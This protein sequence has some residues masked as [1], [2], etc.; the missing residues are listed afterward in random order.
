MW[1]AV[2][3]RSLAE[4]DLPDGGGTV[5]VWLS[6][7]FTPGLVAARIEQAY[8]GRLADE[9]MRSQFSTVIEFE[10]LGF[11]NGALPT[12]GKSAEPA[13]PSH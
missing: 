5:D 8:A 3:A 6:T 12:W 4:G 1:N 10:L 11:G 2:S 9:A 7:E 13:R